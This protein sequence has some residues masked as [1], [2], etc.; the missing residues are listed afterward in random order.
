MMCGPY[1]QG[2]Q[3]GDC[4]G[5][6]RLLGE[7]LLLFSS[8]YDH[9]R[10]VAHLSLRPRSFCHALPVMFAPNAAAALLALPFLA[11][12]AYAQT[13]ARSYTVQEGDICNSISAAH[14]VST[15]QL[16][17]VNAAINADCSNLTPGETLCLGYAGSDCTTTYVVALGDDCDSVAQA[18]SLNTTVL[19]E[20]NPQI[21]ASCENL[22]VGEVLCVAN[23]AEVPISGS[24]TAS[25][26]TAIP[27]TA[28]LANATATATPSITVVTTAVPSASASASSTGDDSGDDGDD[29]DLPWCDEL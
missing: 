21:D 29:G 9:P 19:Y 11:H 22:Y 10:A 2:R 5:Q 25:I 12:A 15:Y 6:R 28:T 17:A 27:T 24:I 23:D 16:A 26:A 7:R 4:R 20:N 13:C 3:G 14:N 18:H 8:S 1:S